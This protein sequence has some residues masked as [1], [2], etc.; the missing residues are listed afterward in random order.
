MMMQQRL[1]QSRPHNL[2]AAPLLQE[3]EEALFH[4][5]A[6]FLLRL[7][8]GQEQSDILRIFHYL[9]QNPQPKP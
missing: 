2:E 9:G 5:E 4:L 8:E 7:E 3:A 6:D 1:E